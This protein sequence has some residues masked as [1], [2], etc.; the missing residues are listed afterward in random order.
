MSTFASISKKLATQRPHRERSQP[1]ARAHLGLLEK[2]VDYKARAKDYK[3]K[4]D[5]L[6]KLRK[7]AL[8]KNEDEYHHHMINSEVKADGRHFEKKTK[9]ADEDSEIQKKLNDV[10]DL[11][12]VK[13]KL[14]SENKKIAELKSELH[15]ADPS[16]GGPGASRHTIFVDSDEEAKVFDPLEYFDTDEVVIAHSYNRLRKSDLVAKSVVGA[17]NKEVVK[18][19]DRLRRARYSEL[20]KRQQR[21]KELEIVAAKLQL[22]KDLAQSQGSE[23][24]PIMVKPGKADSAGLWKWT[25]ERKR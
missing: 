10:K 19:A 5:T 7:H 14:Y 3:E 11:E 12:Y 17:H 22:K 18:K 4:R 15:F 23:L 25:Y 20:M 13:Y 1:N 21:A 9:K 16:C 8:D 6:K 2:K 24:Q